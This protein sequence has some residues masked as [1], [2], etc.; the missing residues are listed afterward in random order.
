MTYLVND[1]VPSRITDHL[2]EVEGGCW[3]WGRAH[4]TAGYACVWWE[5]SQRSLHRVLYVLLRG[6]PPEGMVLDHIVCENKW[7][8]NPWHVEPTTNLANLMR[9]RVR[10]GHRWGCEH[11]TPRCEACYQ[12]YYRDKQRQTLG[13][14]PEWPSGK[15]FNTRKGCLTTKQDRDLRAGLAAGGST[16]ELA[17]EFGISRQAV[18]RR[19]RAA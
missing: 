4:S 13:I 11:S 7:C 19:K 3:K 14:P 6:A 18:W 16:T 17:E 2:T 15:Q 5:G 1:K 10:G 9:E 12:A 8:A